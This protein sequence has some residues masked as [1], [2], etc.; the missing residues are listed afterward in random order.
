MAVFL[1]AGLDSGLIAA[2]ARRRLPEPPVTFTLT[3]DVLAGTPQD[4]GPL[5]AEVARALGTRHVERRVG[6][7]DFAGLWP[8]A[9]AAMDQPSIDGFNTFVVSRAAHE[10][11]LKVVLSGLGGDEVFGSYPSFRDVPALE[12]AARRL[13]RLPGL[14]AA[15]PAP[16]AA[17]RRG[18]A[19]A[20]RAA[21][22]RPLPRRR[23]LPA[24]RALPARG[25][26]RP[27]RTRDRRGGAAALRSA[28]R[29]AAAVRL[30]TAARGGSLA[31]R[32]PAGD[33]ALH[34]PP[35]PAR[36]RTGPRW[37]G[38]S[39]CACRWSTPGCAA[40][41]AAADFEPA[42][43]QG[44]AALVR[45]AAP[46]LPA[47]L[48]DAPEDGLLHPGPGVAGPGDRAPAAGRPLAAA[49]APGARGDGDMVDT[50]LIAGLAAEPPTARL[51]RWAG[52]LSAFFTAQGLVQLAGIAAGLLLVRTLPV[53]EFAL[54]TLAL[55]VITFFTFLS[56]LGSTGSLVH[57]FH[58]PG[59]R[60]RSSRRIWPPCCRCAAS[61]SCSG[62]LAVAVA[63][64]YAAAAKGYGRV[65]IALTLGG[66]LLSVWFQIGAAVRVLALRLG[67]RYGA[68]YRAEVA[69][70][71]LRLLLTV[72]AMVAGALLR[73]WIGV[74]ASAAAARP[75]P[76]LLAGARRQRRSPRR[77]RPIC[78]PT[79]AACSATC[80][81]PCRAPSTSAVQGPLDRLAGGH[82]R[83][84]PQHRRGRR[85]HPARPGRGAVLQPERRGLPAA[86]GADRRRARSG[87]PATSSSAARS[88]AIALT[89]LAA[90]ALLPGPFLW[91]L[92]AQLHGPAPRAR[93][94]GGRRRAHP[95][96]RLR[97][98]RQPGPRVD[99]LADGD[100]DRRDPRAGGAGRRPPA[101][102]HGRRAPLFDLGTA[103]GVAL[104][105]VVTWLGFHHPA[106]V[107]WRT[108]L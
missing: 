34:A 3:F 37:P 2:L 33:R 28:P 96:R 83:R 51:R 18:P 97:G 101:L 48:F 102:H 68:S 107:E 63:F 6:R 65:E 50:R 24:A 16:G 72:A 79:A 8:A 61:A 35:A 73:A 31:R 25:A 59:G 75:R 4:E 54:Y 30:L 13:G 100:R 14:A 23:L 5:A 9:L 84:H 29:Q 94:G 56:D 86:P 95:P 89:L 92:G 81:R 80:C 15:W 58:R 43:S 10:A 52:I 77:W 7:A 90:A 1:S 38:R 20:A 17:R 42:R 99:A 11:G 53:R 103:T 46:E 47:A 19:E 57:F 32:P 93:A 40:H 76:S 22:L 27:A 39:S 85:P 71:A 66:I 87:A 106:R 88:L 108:S 45:Q 82:L 67:D 26:A 55:S 44:K 49:G 91:L 98:E 12:R 105:V 74:L 62:P 70:A 78:A 104:Q 41:L 60:A 36:L 21:P 64:P 69:G